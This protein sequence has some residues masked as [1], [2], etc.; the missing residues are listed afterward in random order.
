M[1]A[2]AL[3][4]H[5]RFMR[6]GGF[7]RYEQDLL[8]QRKPIITVADPA[9]RFHHLIVR[10]N[11]IDL[12]ARRPLQVWD[13]ARD[14]FDSKILGPHFE[15]LA[16]EWVVWHGREVGL[17]DIGHVGQTTVSCRAH[18]GH[19]VDVVAL[20]RESS[21]R[22]R[23][24]RITVLGEA[25][26]TRARPV[27]NL[28]RLTHIRDLLTDLGWDTTDTKLAL[29]APNGVHHAARWRAPGRPRDDVRVGYRAVTSAA[30]IGRTTYARISRNGTRPHARR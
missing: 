23:G 2:K 25:K 6:H 18:R 13:R 19:V 5:L 11:L 29:F 21:P 20:G 3:A 4:Y 7:I 26:S 22:G 9:V 10:P 28:D 24:G 14:T 12:E 8:W 30:S 16:R 15:Q 17:D 27:A 1:D